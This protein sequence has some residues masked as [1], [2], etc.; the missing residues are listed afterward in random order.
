MPEFH[1]AYE[2]QPGRAPH[3]EAVVDGR[4]S[5]QADA[6]RLIAVV[7]QPENLEQLGI[8]LPL[9]RPPG[10]IEEQLAAVG[11]EVTLRVVLDPFRLTLVHAATPG[12]LHYLRLADATL[13]PL[14]PEYPPSRHYLTPD[15]DQSQ[16]GPLELAP[17][18]AY[19]AL[20]PGIARLADSPALARFLHLRDYFN[21]EKLTRALLAQVV[22]LAGALGPAGQPPEDVTILVVEVR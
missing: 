1:I 19:I 9:P 7:R 20:S 14:P 12:V 15:R 6:L 10:S 2:T 13:I 17:G 3:H 11:F 22:E 4:L 21:A 16:G 5:Y 8:P 18:D